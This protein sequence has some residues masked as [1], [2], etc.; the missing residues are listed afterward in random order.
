MA[1]CIR[2]TPVAIICALSMRKTIHGQVILYGSYK[3]KCK[4]RIAIG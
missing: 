4:V 2:T 1:T 3:E